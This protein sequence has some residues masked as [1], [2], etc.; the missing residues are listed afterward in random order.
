MIFPVLDAASP[1]LII[2]I[3]GGGLLI[4]LTVIALLAM[5]V[6]LIVRKIRNRSVNEVRP[7]E[8]S[9]ES[10]TEE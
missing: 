7:T 5:S 3:L 4:L 10:H 6:I 2:G 8:E 9:T 1:G